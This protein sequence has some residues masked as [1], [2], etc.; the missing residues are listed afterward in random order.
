MLVR[1]GKSA[2]RGISSASRDGRSYDNV[3]RGNRIWVLCY[4][5]VSKWC[6]MAYGGYDIGIAGGKSG[7][8]EQVNESESKSKGVK[9]VTDLETREEVFMET[10]E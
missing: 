2:N 1:I 9:K 3:V 10:K 7:V 8:D 5:L 4:D 6:L